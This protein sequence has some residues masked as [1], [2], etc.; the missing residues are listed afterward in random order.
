VAAKADVVSVEALAA[1]EV[2]HG[3]P[4]P[5]ELRGSGDQMLRGWIRGVGD[6]DA[7]LLHGV[8]D[9]SRVFD[10]LLER[11]PV[12]LRG[13]AVDL[14]GHG[15]S[16]WSSTS[17]YSR[18]SFRND[19]EQVIAELPGERVVLVGHSL[20]GALALELAAA[21]PERIA[22]LCLLD[23]GPAVE[24]P[25]IQRLE[26]GLAEDA[27]EYADLDDYTAS[28]GQRYWLA[29][30]RA[31]ARF[32]RHAVRRAESGR[33]VPKLDPA[34]RNVLRERCDGQPGW[35]QLRRVACPVLVVRAVGS[36]VLSRAVAQR[37]V[38]ALPDG[39]LCEIPRAGHALL[40]DN[41][42]VVS[43]VVAEFLCS[44]LGGRTRRAAAG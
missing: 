31:L 27:R 42:Q 20:G 17:D 44:L 10:P 18:A 25:A 16:A 14:R 22:G 9:H 33:L 3:E 38:E 6:C 4:R 26:T 21:H 2:L 19:L 43:G 15:D 35:A 32:A 5:C 36:A 13:L 39:R 29:E 23:I 37:M 24:P 40:L 1:L 34:A 28:L 7:L 11:L 41:P 12:G 8:G 30:G